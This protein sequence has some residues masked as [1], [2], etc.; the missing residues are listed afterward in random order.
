MV[1]TSKQISY[2]IVSGR[3]FVWL[4]IHSM[5]NTT[6]ILQIEYTSVFIKFVKVEFSKN[7]IFSWNFKKKL[8]KNSWAEFVPNFKNWIFP[9]KCQCRYF[10]KMSMLNF[11]QKIAM[12]NFVQKNI[13]GEFSFFF[14]KCQGRIFSSFII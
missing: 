7:Y 14:Q 3:H 10:V 4:Q 2:T 1:E 8:L 11:S 12:L 9:Q 13:N 6:H 5:K